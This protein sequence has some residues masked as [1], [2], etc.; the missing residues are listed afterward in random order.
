MI[1]GMKG[2]TQQRRTQLHLPDSQEQE[3]EEQDPQPPV[4]GRETL[5]RDPSKRSFGC[6]EGDGVV[7]EERD[8]SCDYHMAAAQ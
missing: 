5:A 1:G 6:G 7:A 4:E 3:S 8:R 2:W